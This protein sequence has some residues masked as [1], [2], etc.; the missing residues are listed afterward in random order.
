MII[1]WSSWSW[2]SATAINLLSLGPARQVGLCPVANYCSSSYSSPVSTLTPA[3]SPGNSVDPRGSGVLG[4][5][6]LLGRSCPGLHC[7][8]HLTPSMENTAVHTA[9]GLPSSETAKLCCSPEVF[10]KILPTLLGQPWPPAASLQHAPC[11]HTAFLSFLSPPVPPGPRPKSFPLH[12]S[13][14]NQR[15][16]WAP[17][18]YSQSDPACPPEC[19]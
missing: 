3:H 6:G 10:G 4:L 13:H 7:T 15:L 18:P 12:S 14:K 19:P 8:P 1:P 11:H 17:M 9:L 16:P 2:G 5:W